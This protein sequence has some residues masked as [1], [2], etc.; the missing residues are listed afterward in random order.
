[1]NLSPLPLAGL[2][3]ELTTF[4]PTRVVGVVSYL[5]AGIAAAVAAKRGGNKVIWGLVALVL[6]YAA[7][8][9]QLGLRHRVAEGF[10]GAW[11]SLGL[12]D[13]RKPYQIAVLVGVGAAVGVGIGVL[14]YRLRRAGWAVQLA[15][16]AT[17]LTVALL[18]VEVLSLH[19]TD[20]LLY[21]SVP[22]PVMAIGYAWVA[23]AGV[24]LAAGLVEGVRAWRG[25]RS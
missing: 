18:G 12:R 16:G 17:G 25:R 14:V 9:I 11:T 6:F 8:D 10:S 7:V 15:A 2:L 19:A 23:L 1:M 22:G 4:N 24:V 13:Q 21:R 3:T 5:A 20:A